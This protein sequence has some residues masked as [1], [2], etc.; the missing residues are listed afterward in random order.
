MKKLCILGVVAAVMSSQGALAQTKDYQATMGIR[1][2]NYNGNGYDDHE[3]ELRAGYFLTPVKTAGLPVS[4]AYFLGRNSSISGY[5]FRDVNHGASNGFGVA[6]DFWLNKI[7]LAANVGKN[8]GDEYYNAR[9]GFLV[10]DG[11]L[12]SLRA[13]NGDNYDKTS[14]ALSTKYV[15]RLGEKYVALNAAVTTYNDD[16][17]LAVGGEYFFTNSFSAQAGV[18]H[19]DNSS[20]D[21]NYSVGTSYYF[22]SLTSIKLYFS[23]SGNDNMLYLD[24][25]A[26][27]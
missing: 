15:G 11:W 6:G 7:N 5:A 24:L 16:N 2:Y 26:R 18:E 12:V 21:T 8:Y 9:I 13:A 20:V 22:A 25:T 17:Y 4:E 14:Y 3:L 23:R 19:S 1:Y 27:Y 10:R